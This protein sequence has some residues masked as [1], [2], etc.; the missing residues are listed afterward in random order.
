MMY[1]LL[2][3]EGFLTAARAFYFVA[4]ISFTISLFL[5]QPEYYNNQRWGIILIDAITIFIVYVA[6]LLYLKNIIGL[7]LNCVL[8]IYGTLINISLSTW[9]YFYHD[10]Y[11]SSNF[12]FGTFIFCIYIVI[13]GF[14]I[15]HKQVFV[16]AGFYMIFFFPLIFV[17]GNAYLINNVIVLPYLIIA[18]SF[19]VSSFLY[20]F[21]SSHK[22]ELFLKEKLHNKDK[23]LF[24]EKN[25]RLNS[26]L[27]NKKRE[28]MAK[29]MFLLKHS[30]NY[31]SFV[32]ELN[33][34]KGGIKN[35]EQRLL[36]TIIRK[37][38]IEQYNSYFKEFKNIF[39][40]IHPQFYKK[41]YRA[42]PL[43]SPSEYKLAAMLHLGL[44]SKQI[45]GITSVTPESVDVAR[46]RLRKKLDLSS[47]TKL[48]TYLLAL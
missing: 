10:I 28:L 1:K 18:F 21:E 42:C 19:A 31:N 48:T 35:S 43:L 38:S 4:L 26:E 36:N 22:R 33:L 34:L 29:T 46:S 25:H 6:L 8:F 41:L 39:L 37:H 7:R 9:Y 11:F 32:K 12:L 47:E 3:N 40:E 17:S 45:A 2:N 30:D 27:E 13:A 5:N 16:V 20:L 14:C 15:G 24:R 23:L 44:S